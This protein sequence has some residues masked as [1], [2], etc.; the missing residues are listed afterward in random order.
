MLPFFKKL[1]TSNYETLSGEAFQ[2]QYKTT[3]GA[4]LID[5]RTPAEFSGGSIR[6]ARNINVV[7]P[8]FKNAIQ[9]LDKEKTYFIFCRSGARSRNACRQMSNM[10]F[11]VYNLRGGIGAWRD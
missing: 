9:T 4:V 3:R 11:K 8:S 5:V 10:G 7:S 1:F 6:G 2:K